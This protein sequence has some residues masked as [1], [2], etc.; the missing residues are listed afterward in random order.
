MR[1][2]LLLCF[3]CKT[4]VAGAQKNIP[5][6]ISQKAC[7]L[8]RFMDK[9]HYQPLLWNDSASTMLY[10]KW[11]GKLDEEKLFLTQKDIDVLESLKQN[12]IT[13]CWK[14]KLIFL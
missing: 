12:W 5:V 1:K 8:M 14:K 13:N 9:N 7:I 4:I 10:N 3:L 6:G 2:I 11:L